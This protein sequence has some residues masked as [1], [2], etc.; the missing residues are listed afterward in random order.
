MHYAWNAI[1]SGPGEF[2][3]AVVFIP[4]AF[5]FLLSEYYFFS[6]SIRSCEKRTIKNFNSSLVFAYLCDRIPDCLCTSNECSSTRTN[7]KVEEEEPYSFI[8]AH[9]L[10]CISGI[11]C[12]KQSPNFSIDKCCLRAQCTRSHTCV[13]AFTKHVK[14]IRTN[15][16]FFSFVR[17]DNLQV[18]ARLTPIMPRS[19]FAI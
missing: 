14:S 6:C 10:L 13:D 19:H 15:L 2:V 1:S 18:I 12:S 11:E 17:E 16:F 5:F 8:F 4:L 9:I 7:C 3:A